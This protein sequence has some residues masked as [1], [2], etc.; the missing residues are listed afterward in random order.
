MW[1]RILNGFFSFCL[2][3]FISNVYAE[4]PVSNDEP[5]QSISWQEIPGASGYILEIKNSNGYMVL[6]EKTTSNSYNVTNLGS[7]VYE[8]RVG[9]INKL[10]KVGAYSEWVK[11][12]VVVSKVPTLTND[13]IYSISKEDKQKVF[14]LQGTDF[15]DQMRV[16]MVIDGKKIPAKKIEVESAT[17]ARVVFDIDPSMNTGIYDLV[18]EN[19]RKKALNVKQRIVFSETKEKAERFA[20]RQER[21]LKK[22]IPEDYYETP[23]WSTF[24]R[25]SLIPG[26]GQKY[27]DGQNWKFYVY[28]VVAIG[29]AGA[30]ASSYSKFQS[31]KSSYESAVLVGVF[32]AEDPNSQALWLLNRNSAQANFNSAK[33][34]LTTIQTGAGVLG[35]FVLYN[36]V[37]AYFSARRNVAGLETAPGLPL[38]Q[39]TARVN[40]KMAADPFSS[41]QPVSGYNVSSS[42]QVEFSLRY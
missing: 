14:N 35:L 11:L 39:E 27:I 17:R 34:Q 21:I 24:W 41:I 1:N 16:Y 15:V 10:G 30:Y 9:V 42:Y 7:G 2:V 38:G 3:F 19:P 26:W 23:Y 37:D 5:P 18:L 36:L 22:E 33:Q 20:T 40:A 8:H 13:S 28:P 29:V 32:L 12:E 6:S 31:A 4:D 25:S